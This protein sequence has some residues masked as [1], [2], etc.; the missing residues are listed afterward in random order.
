MQLS[1]SV[2]ARGPGP[3]LHAGTFR[4]VRNPTCR[5]PPMGK[6][7]D[8]PR[9]ICRL[10]EHS[11]W[12]NQHGR[13]LRRGAFVVNITI[14]YFLVASFLASGISAPPRFNFPKKIPRSGEKRVNRLKRIRLERRSTSD[15]THRKGTPKPPL[16]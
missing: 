12:T 16:G 2:W 1:S 5:V 3:G 14:F 9:A 10:V 6:I 15:G 11:L 7:I 8:Q 4:R 13:R